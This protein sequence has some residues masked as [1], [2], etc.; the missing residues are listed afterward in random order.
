MTRARP[1]VATHYLRYT[2]GNVLVMVA[3]F[4]SYPIMARLLDYTQLGIFGYYDTW[5]LILAGAFKLGGQH[6]ILRFYPHRGGSEE[7][8]RFGANFVLLP[9]L[10]SIGFWILSLAAFGIYS[11]TQ[12]MSRA[13]IGW[14]VLAALLPT[15]WISFVSGV[16]SAEE[17]SELSVRV[18][19]SWKWLEVLTILPIIYFVARNAEGV[20]VGRLIAAAL[21]AVVLVA[22]LWRRLPMHWRDRNVASW[23]EGVRY[24]V[25]MMANE[26]SSVLLSFV[27]RLMLRHMLG[28]FAPV[29]V[30][31]IGYGLA[32]TINALIQSAL[33]VA[34][35]QVSVRQFETEGP[36]A[37]LRTKHA[38]LH[39][40]VYVIVAAI[41]GLIVVGDDALTLLAGHAK[42][43]SAPVFVLIAINYLLNGLFSLCSAGLILYKR[44]GVIFATTCAATIL[45]VILNLF[46]IPAYGV[47]GAVWAT[48]V[49]FMVL[50][51]ARY[52]MCPRNLRALPDARATC[53]AVLLACVVWAIAHFSGLFGAS[54]RLP[55]LLVTAG[56]L[57][58]FYA[59]PALLLDAPL[60]RS[61]REWWERRRGA[62]T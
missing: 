42:A 23:W 4:V 60:R 16:F 41:V 9:L 32:M 57:L 15:I 53:I 6:A 8:A 36:E 46:W 54:S 20:Y 58:V 55:R 61:I 27:D 38:V 49:S 10:C 34:F 12:P 37:V 51:L 50:N 47:M 59:G 18:N 17:R 62:L 25:P 48:L 22:W 1:G 3:G 19:V 26:L 21:V 40:L 7:L 2:V 29:G 31:T 14:L 11:A 24:G 44:S 28:A 39:V 35:T 56:L 45:N 30:Y 33:N 52:I 13:V 43:A 5:L